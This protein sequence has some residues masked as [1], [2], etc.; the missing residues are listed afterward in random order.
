M[1][2]PRGAS[3]KEFTCK[4]GDSNSDPWVRKIPWR[5]KWQPTPYCLENP[6]DR[7]TWQAHE[8]T[9]HGDTELDMTERACT[10]MP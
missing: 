9:V 8:V 3:G 5:R 2:F 6:M 10:C 1:G 7:G 4:A